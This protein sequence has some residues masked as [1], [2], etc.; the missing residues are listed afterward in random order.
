MQKIC[1]DELETV[2]S[3]LDYR[4]E[5]DAAVRLRAFHACAE[6]S[7]CSYWQSC[8]RR[9]EDIWSTRIAQPSRR[10]A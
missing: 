9:L 10:P 3:L 4:M 8:V 2:R 1:I 6:R 7:D 5:A